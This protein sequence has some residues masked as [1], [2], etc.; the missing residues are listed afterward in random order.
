M[1]LLNILAL[2]KYALCENNIHFSLRNS[3]TSTVKQQELGVKDW[4][5]YSQRSNLTLNVYS[6]IDNSESI[7]ED[8]P[9]TLSKGNKMHKKF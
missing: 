5:N 1:P 7:I 8:D 9:P 3:E 4:N 6:I 2:Q